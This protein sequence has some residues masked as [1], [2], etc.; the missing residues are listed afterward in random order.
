[1]KVVLRAFI[2]R[3]GG[4]WGLIGADKSRYPPLAHNGT[5]VRAV[6]A[7]GGGVSVPAAGMAY[8]G[9]ALR[10]GG[11][12]C[13]LC[14]VWVRVVGGVLPRAV[15]CGVRVPCVLCCCVSGAVL[16]GVPVLR[17]PCNYTTA[18]PWCGDSINAGVRLDT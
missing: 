8:T 17:V 16:R 2:S 3:L 15:A 13:V 14:W 4:R 18:W 1:V 10:C 5:Y 9:G 6:C 7:R 11:R 12:V